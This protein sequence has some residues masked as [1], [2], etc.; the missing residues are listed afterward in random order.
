MK[1][2]SSLHRAEAFN[3]ALEADVA[4]QNR[5]EA[6]EV[7]ERPSTPA[8]L[9]VEPGRVQLLKGLVTVTFT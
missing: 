8:Q 1:Y 7:I 6:L 5:V 9:D 4:T 3:P 2:P